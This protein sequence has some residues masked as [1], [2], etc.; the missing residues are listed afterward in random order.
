VAGFTGMTIVCVV[1]RGVV[2]DMETVVGGAACTVACAGAAGGLASTGAILAATAGGMYP[3]A[4]PILM[5]AAH[6]APG[7]QTEAAR[8]AGS[9]MGGR[10]LRGGGST[11]ILPPPF[12]S[13]GI[14]PQ[15]H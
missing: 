14:Y 6:S 4:M 9:V 13:R 1:G 8:A 12:T 11:L 15:A 5:A 2:G 7:L 10:A 3:C